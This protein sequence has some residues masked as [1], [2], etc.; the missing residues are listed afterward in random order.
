[1]QQG[2]F[3]CYAIS[4]VFFLKRPLLNCITHNS[5]ATC[6]SMVVPF[7][8]KQEIFSHNPRMKYHERRNSLAAIINRERKIHL[9]QTNCPLVNVSEKDRYKFKINFPYYLRMDE[10][11]SRRLCLSLTLLELKEKGLYRNK[12]N[13]LHTG[14]LL[15]HLKDVPKILKYRLR[16]ADETKCYT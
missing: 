3:F 9:Q 8:S 11:K 12:C 2:T 15:F 1:M 14:H 7:S 6:T 4:N 16:F 13:V 10:A 5:K